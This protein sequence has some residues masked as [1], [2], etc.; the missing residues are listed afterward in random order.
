MYACNCYDW[1]F[2]FSVRVNQLSPSLSLSFFSYST[3]SDY[4]HHNKEYDWSRKWQPTPVFLPGESPW[5]EQ[6]GRLESTGLQSWT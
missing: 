3:F 6:P 1:L 5:T 4:F 2:C